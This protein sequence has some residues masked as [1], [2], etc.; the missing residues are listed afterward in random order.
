MKKL[1][2]LILIVICLAVFGCKIDPSIFS[3]QL[4]FEASGSVMEVIDID[5]SLAYE[6]VCQGQTFTLDS[7]LPLK[8]KDEVVLVFIFE[9]QQLNSYNLTEL[10]VDSIKTQ[11]GL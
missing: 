10:W 11:P 3:G 4:S 6:I 8:Y 7:E 1:F 5:G 9:Q 2:V